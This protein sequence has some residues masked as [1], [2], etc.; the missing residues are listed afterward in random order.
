MGHNTIT[1]NANTIALAAAY[2][3]T[4]LFPWDSKITLSPTGGVRISGCQFS[5]NGFISATVSDGLGG[6]VGTRNGLMSMAAPKIRITNL[7]GP[8]L[9]KTLG[10][11]A[12]NFIFGIGTYATY[13]T[14]GVAKLAGK[15]LDNTDLTATIINA[16]PTIIVFEL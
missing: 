10:K 1:I 4:S 8:A 7:G 13:A 16:I 11:M 15:E 5:A 9:L 6:S 14:G 2:F 12:D 3:K